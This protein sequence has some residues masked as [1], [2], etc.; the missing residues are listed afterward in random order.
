MYEKLGAPS[1]KQRSKRRSMNMTFGPWSRGLL[2]DRQA[3]QAKKSDLMEAL[4]IVLVEEGIARTRDGSTL[5]CTGCTGSVTQSE[6][7]QVDDIWYQ[8]IADSD[9]KIYKQ[10]GAGVE[11]IGPFP[12]EVRFLSFMEVIL[13]FDGES[14]KYWDGTTVKIAYDDGTGT[15]GP[16]QYNNLLETDTKATAIRSGE[17]FTVPFTSLGWSAGYEIPPTVFFA[18]M[19]KVAA[20]AGPVNVTILDGVTTVATGVFTTLAENFVTDET[21][22]EYEV[23][24]DQA[25]I[26][27]ELDPETP[28]TIEI[29]FPTGDG[30]D[31]IEIRQAEDNTALTALRPGPAPAADFGVVSKGRV[32]V[33]G[34]VAQG[35]T[36]Y[37]AAGNFLDWSTPNGGGF[38]GAVDDSASNFPIGALAEFFGTVYFFGTVDQP[39]MARLS[40]SDPVDYAI[41]KVVD[42]VSA[43]H[44]SIITTPDNVWFL[45]PTGVDSVRSTQEHGDVAVSTQT[46]SIKSSINRY[47]SEGAVAGFDPV[48]GLYCLKMEGTDEIYIVH[49]RLKSGRS[50]GQKSVG[51]SPVTRWKYE[52]PDPVSCFGPGG[53]GMVIGTEGGE[54]YA[55]DKN[56]TQ[57]N[58]VDPEY[59]IRAF[60]QVVPFGEGECD[61]VSVTASGLF[62]ASFDVTFYR[63]YRRDELFSIHFVA[64]IDSR[65]LTEDVTVDTLDADFLSNPEYVVDRAEVNFNFR[66]IQ[67]GVNNIVLSGQPLYIGAI[68]IMAA[69]IGG[70]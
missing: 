1:A 44:K 49:T 29:D 62:G 31:Y 51:F 20:A 41:N 14:V 33:V 46:D 5:L 38:L 25:D 45:H 58:E 60:A 47:Y 42:N 23:I 55:M 15:I 59:E 48:W 32:F 57:D 4:N 2:T 39:Y 61:K 66:S 40:G 68:K 9:G 11:L 8:V 7:V 13:I 22:A 21:G 12:G 69:S 35:E 50:Q 16:Y 65:V 28:Y 26:V 18:K 30:T 10:V 34:K 3:E 52:F 56:V 27:S 37:C 67:V 6:W 17:K 64:P 24:F 43:D 19:R 36:W 53:G 70:F 63:D 54:L